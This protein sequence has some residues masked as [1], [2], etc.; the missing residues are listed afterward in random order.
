MIHI[1]QICT[2]VG[3]NQ[4]KKKKEKEAFYFTCNAS[5]VSFNSFLIF[6]Q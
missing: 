6:E 1:I 2:L 5:S 3:S 4:T